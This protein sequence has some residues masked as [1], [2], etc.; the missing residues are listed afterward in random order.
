MSVQL[1]AIVT[2]QPMPKV[3]QIEQAKL[4]QRVSESARAALRGSPASLARIQA[5]VAERRHCHD[6]DTHPRLTGWYGCTTCPAMMG[7]LA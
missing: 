4:F 7:P 3:W 6:W 5:K 2:R 1:A